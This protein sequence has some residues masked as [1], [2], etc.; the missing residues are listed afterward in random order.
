MSGTNT[1]EV[2]SNSCSFAM[3]F[4]EL[5]IQGIVVTGVTNGTLDINFYTE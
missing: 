3:C 4:N 5:E 1:Y 2:I